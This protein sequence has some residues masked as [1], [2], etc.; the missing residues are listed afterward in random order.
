M[1][2]EWWSL[3][4][5]GAAD[6]VE[7]NAEMA[8]EQS[9]YRRVAAMKCGA[10]DRNGT[11]ILAPKAFSKQ[12][13]AAG[14]ASVARC[15]KQAGITDAVCLGSVGQQPADQGIRLDRFSLA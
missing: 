3:A 7:V 8:F 15:D 4:A 10:S 2:L 9:Q 5:A 6:G 1:R 14:T 11:T 13:Q 12:S